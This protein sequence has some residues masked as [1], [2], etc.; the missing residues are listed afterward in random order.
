[1]KHL[2]YLIIILVCFSGCSSKKKEVVVS[3]PVVEK[4]E[5]LQLAKIILKPEK[6]EISVTRDPF[7]PLIELNKGPAALVLNIGEQLERYKFM[8]VTKSDDEYVAFIK[9]GAKRG[10]YRKNDMLNEFKIVD[11]GPQEVLLLNGEKTFTLK[12]GK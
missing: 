1:M 3:E 4:V 8:G 6:P 7:K 12:R 10:T 2:I 5:D 9:D 11:I